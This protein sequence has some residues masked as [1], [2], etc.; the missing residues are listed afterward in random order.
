MSWKEESLLAGEPWGAKRRDGAVSPGGAQQPGRGE[1]AAQKALCTMREEKATQSHGREQPCLHCSHLPGQSC[2]AGG[3]LSFSPGLL[4]GRIRARGQPVTLAC[5]PFAQFLLFPVSPSCDLWQSHPKYSPKLCQG[6]ERL[7]ALR[8]GPVQ[9]HRTCH[10][11]ISPLFRKIH[12]PRECP[13]SITPEAQ[14]LRGT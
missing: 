13:S 4:F 6:T 5:F 10:S 2:Y 8:P 12:Q 11:W 7:R 1:G 14:E 9:G 3:N